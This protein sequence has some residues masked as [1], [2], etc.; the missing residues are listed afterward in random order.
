MILATGDFGN[1]VHVVLYDSRNGIIV[2]VARFTVL[3]EHIGVLGSTA[4]RRILGAES[5]LA[6]VAE[7]V[8]VDKCGQ[9]LLV[10]SFDFLNF[11]R[12]AETVEEVNKRHL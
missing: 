3:E 9:I 4:S 2:F 10:D 5:T 1:L 12:S 6:E 11:V 7:S 8:L